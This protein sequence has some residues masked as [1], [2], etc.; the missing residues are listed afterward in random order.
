MSGA[1][2]DCSERS[3]ETR[4]ADWS[5]R[6]DVVRPA[7]PCASGWKLAAREAFA[8]RTLGDHERSEIGASCGFLSSRM[9]ACGHGRAPPRLFQ[10][11][12]DSVPHSCLAFFAG[13][14][15]PLPC[16]GLIVHIHFTAQDFFLH[17]FLLPETVSFHHGIPGPKGAHNG[18][19][20]LEPCRHT[21]YC[22]RR[23]LY[24]VPWGCGYQLCYQKRR[25]SLL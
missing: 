9:R 21:T 23:C 4:R 20:N 18:I 11:H 6:W 1:N 7:L 12:R 2:G 14:H 8:A 17:A 24:D 13:L 5:H 15:K 3:S 19:R 16:I 10:S 25:G 22:R